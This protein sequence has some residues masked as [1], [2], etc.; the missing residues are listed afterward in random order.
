MFTLWAAILTSFRSLARTYRMRTL[1]LNRYLNRHGF[2]LFRGMHYAANTLKISR[3]DT[4][5]AS[6]SPASES[7]YRLVRKSCFLSV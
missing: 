4:L 7:V 1:V 5:R 3:R 6:A 2:L